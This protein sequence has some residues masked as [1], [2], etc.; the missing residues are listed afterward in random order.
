M[1]AKARGLALRVSELDD[2]TTERDA[3]AIAFYESA[4]AFGEVPKD[5]MHMDVCFE[6]KLLSHCRR[7]SVDTAAYC[8]NAQARGRS[9]TR[10]SEKAKLWLTMITRG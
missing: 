9:S 6:P 10:Y 8:G 4:C 5:C 2:D 3:C 7:C 1:V